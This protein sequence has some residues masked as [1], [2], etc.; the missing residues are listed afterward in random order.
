MLARLDDD[1]TTYSL[2]PVSRIASM[3]IADDS[4]QSIGYM[5][6]QSF[7]ISYPLLYVS[8]MHYIS[9]H[10][11][12]VTFIAYHQIWNMFTTAIII[13]KVDSLNVMFGPSGTFAPIM[14][15]MSAS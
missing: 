7:N 3:T 5:N 6:N 13:D 10:L 9:L 2:S 1:E 8:K 11:W 15:V 12:F 14:S 4:G